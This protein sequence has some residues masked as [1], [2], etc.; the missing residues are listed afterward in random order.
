RLPEWPVLVIFQLEKLKLNE[1]RRYSD[2]AM[3]DSPLLRVYQDSKWN[4][5]LN[6]FIYV[7]LKNHFYCIG[8]AGCC[9]I[10]YGH[11]MWQFRR[12]DYLFILGITGPQQSNYSFDYVLL[13]HQTESVN[14]GA[15]CAERVRMRNDRFSNI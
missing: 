1:F 8:Y 7:R 3:F 15:E 9:P 11:C 5:H 4:I 6:M 13:T 12:R 2:I 14:I 10:F